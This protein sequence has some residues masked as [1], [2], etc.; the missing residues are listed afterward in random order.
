[1]AD[2][3]TIFNELSKLTGVGPLWLSLP[4]RRTAPLQ[5]ARGALLIWQIG[6]MLRAT[7]LADAKRA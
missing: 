5:N 2:V 6:M 4:I 3:Q 1:M 7:A